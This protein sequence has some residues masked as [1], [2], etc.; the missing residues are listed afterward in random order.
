MTQQKLLYFASCNV[1][2]NASKSAQTFSGTRCP[3]FNRT[4]NERQVVQTSI[5]LTSMRSAS[6]GAYI[7]RK[8]VGSLL[9]KTTKNQRTKQFSAKACLKAV[10]NLG[11][12]RFVAFR[13]SP[14]V[15][16]ER[17]MKVSVVDQDES[18]SS[19]PNCLSC[20]NSH[21]FIP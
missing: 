6:K 1:L 19:G 18:F 14:P 17:K 9:Y 15:T 5:Y 10:L 3:R 7:T 2:C 11:C 21:S 16:S 13:I 12:S 20:D 4:H 8:I